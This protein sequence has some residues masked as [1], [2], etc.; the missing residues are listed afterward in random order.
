[1]YLD[2][3]V[4]SGLVIVLLTCVMMVYVGRYAYRHFKQEMSKS[5]KKLTGHDSKS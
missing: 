4:I 3:V 5:E 1:M 2:S